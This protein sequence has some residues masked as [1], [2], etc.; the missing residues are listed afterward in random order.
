MLT[1]YIVAM[2]VIEKYISTAVNSALASAYSYLTLVHGVSVDPVDF[3]KGVRDAM[4]SPKDS[5]H[6][7]VQ[8]RY[9]EKLNEKPTED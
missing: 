5:D 8:K 3:V 4:K 2:K 9:F 7:F 1:S 6:Y